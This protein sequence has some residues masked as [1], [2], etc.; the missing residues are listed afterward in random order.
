[1]P[2]SLKVLITGCSKHSKEIVDALTLN[3]DCRAVEVV[4]VNMDE[5]KLLQH[6]TSWK[7]VAPPITDEGYIPFLKQVCKE[8]HTNIII[9]YITAELELMAKHKQE[10]EEMGVHVSVT[11]EESL[12]ILNNKERFGAVF[13]EYTPDQYIVSSVESAREIYTAYEKNGKKL[14]CKISGKCGGTGFCIIDNQK[15][16][17][18]SLFNRCGVNRYISDQDIYKIIDVGHKV[19]LQE[20][21]EGV[22]YSV[23]VLADHGKVLGMVGYAGFDMEFGAVV[24]GQIVINRKAFDIVEHIVKKTKVDGN[25]CFDFILEGATSGSG[26]EEMQ[27]APVKLLECNPRI[28]A[29]IGFCWRAGMNMVYLRCKQLMGD[30]IPEDIVSSRTRIKE[31]LRMQK[32]YESEYYI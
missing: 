6:G 29:S 23:C 2:D 24:N 28:N 19:I 12:S 8:T 16:Y 20:Y 7:Y 10:F 30:L 22:D 21:I 32:Y 17:D 13:R 15:A 5:N 9:P 4:A 14:C 3:E 11:S 18:I 31:G 1:M 25:A 27:K 26:I